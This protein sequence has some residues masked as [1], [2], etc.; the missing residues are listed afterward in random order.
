MDDARYV[1]DHGDVLLERLRDVL[2]APGGKRMRVH[3]DLHLGQVLSTGRDFVIIDFEGEP[4][5]S[6]GERRLKRSP[7]RDVAGMLRSFDYAARVSIGEVV[8][9]GTAVSDERAH[10]LLADPAD[11]WVRWASAAFLRGYLSA[12]AGAG[13][14]P[15][16]AEARR[17][18]LDAHT[19]DKALYE[20]RYELEH[21]P[22]WV[23]IPIGGL[24][25]LLEVHTG[26][27][28]ML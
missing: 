27:E 12:V 16:A 9:R 5:R 19:I 3:G 21:R 25:T 4:T 22:S 2:R 28:V 18:Q 11:Q 20:V 24:R 17:I 14:I 23:G 15:D 7:F 26:E 6:I 13:L 10:E 1:L 8:E